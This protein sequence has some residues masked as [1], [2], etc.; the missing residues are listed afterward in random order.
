MSARAS[1]PKADSTRHPTGFRKTHCGYGGHP[2]GHPRCDDSTPFRAGLPLLKRRRRKGKAGA[3]EDPYHHLQAWERQRRGVGRQNSEQREGGGGDPGKGPA[4]LGRRG[5]EGKDEGAHIWK[6]EAGEAARRRGQ[7]P[8]RREAG[9]GGGGNGGKRRRQRRWLRAKFPWKRA[10]DPG[11]KGQANGENDGSEPGGVDPQKGRGPGPCA[12]AEMAARRGRGLPKTSA[13]RRAAGHVPANGCGEAFAA[14]EKRLVQLSGGL[15]P[16][17][18]GGVR[19][20]AAAL[21]PGRGGDPG[22][23]RVSRRKAPFWQ[24]PRGQPVLGNLMDNPGSCEHVS[25]F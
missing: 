24:T 6:T 5:G 3:R 2:H 17:G 22:R 23:R 20:P 1:G 12:D 15:R 8:R 18:A 10:R 7:A 9:K 4:R 11:R 25:Y 14:R 16:P 13:R 19:A 21:R